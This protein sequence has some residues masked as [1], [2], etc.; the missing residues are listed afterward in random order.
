MKLYPKLP[1]CN[2]A[3]LYHKR[4]DTLLMVTDEVGDFLYGLVRLT[5]PI[6][7]VETGTHFGDSAFQIGSALKKNGVGSLI[8]CE[9]NLGYAA[10]ARDRLIDLPVAVSNVTGVELLKSIHAP[11]DFAF[12][13]SGDVPV[14]LEELQLL[15]NITVNP[16]GIVAW[17]DACEGY[18]ALYE[19]FQQRA[20]P[21]LI[22]PSIVGIAVFQRPE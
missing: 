3:S 9:P 7:C 2:R 14:R 17:H 1:N 22:F 16:L 13:D 8:T 12:I 5:K 19:Y 10:R 20:W 4:D 18:D 21:H 6:V 15:H 11:I